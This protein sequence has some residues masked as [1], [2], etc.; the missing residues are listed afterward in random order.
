MCSD[1]YLLDIFINLIYYCYNYYNYYNYFI[2]PPYLAAP[3]SPVSFSLLFSFEC[4]CFSGYLLHPQCWPWFLWDFS[5]CECECVS[6][7]VAPPLPTQNSSIGLVYPSPKSLSFSGDSLRN[8]TPQTARL[9]RR[10]KPKILLC[11][12]TCSLE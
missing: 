2:P 5:L 12:E 3:P 11:S 9:N 6:L 1:L 4:F 8:T 10:Y 7:R